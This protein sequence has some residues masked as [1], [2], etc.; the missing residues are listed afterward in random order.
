LYSSAIA[1][2]CTLRPEFHGLILGLLLSGVFGYYYL[3]LGSATNGQE[4]LFGAVP[5][6]FTMTE[7]HVD[8]ATDFSVS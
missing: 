7:L 8:V 5:W 1:T 4:P 6:S 2:P 3:E